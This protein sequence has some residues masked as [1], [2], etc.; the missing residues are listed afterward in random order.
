MINERSLQVTS[1]GSNA[2]GFP[3]YEKKK[4]L[5]AIRS[6]VADKNGYL[7]YSFNTNSQGR[8]FSVYINGHILSPTE[9]YSSVLDG[10][11]HHLDFIMLKKGDKVKITGG[12][13]IFWWYSCSH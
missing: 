3:D 4:Y 9:S 11:A 13:P 2:I 12:Y 6:F 7:W 1:Q 8:E 10:D 5:G